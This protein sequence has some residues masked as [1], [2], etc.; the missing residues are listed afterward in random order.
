MGNSILTLL[1]TFFTFVVVFVSGRASGQVKSMAVIIKTDLCPASLQQEADD[2]NWRSKATSAEFKLDR[3]IRE[4]PSKYDDALI[5]NAAHISQQRH[6]RP[7]WKLES[8]LDRRQSSAV[9]A[10]YEFPGC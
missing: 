6:Q 10:D 3:F 9:M 5:M 4:N 1:V 7:C 8:H 2:K